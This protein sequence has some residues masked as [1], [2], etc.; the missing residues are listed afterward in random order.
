MKKIK[1]EGTFTEPLNFKIDYWLQKTK[2]LGTIIFFIL[3]A[4]LLLLVSS[5]L[6]KF[7]LDF[8]SLDGTIIAFFGVFTGAVISGVISYLLQRRELHV[9]TMIEKKEEIYDKVYDELMKLKTFTKLIPYPDLIN[10][11]PIMD[12]PE[13]WRFEKWSMIRECNR[14][15][16][17]PL[18]I[19]KP[20]DKLYRDLSSYLSKKETAID[21]CKLIIEELKHENP[22]LQWPTEKKPISIT[23]KSILL[24]DKDFYSKNVEHFFKI[25]DRDKLQSNI[26]EYWEIIVTKVNNSRE[27]QEFQAYYENML[28]EINWLIDVFRKIITFINIKYENHTKV[29]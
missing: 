19:K 17:V 27:I 26:N 1:R 5:L 10:L 24:A 16:T 8:S 9:K 4:L 22:S 28:V 7:Q 12:E 23:L 11:F 18:W 2:P 15:L 29:I 20:L 25:D 13:S 21:A 6:K 3:L 14:Y